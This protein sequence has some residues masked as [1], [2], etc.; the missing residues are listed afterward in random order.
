MNSYEPASRSISNSLRDHVEASQYELALIWGIQWTSGD[1]TFTIRL[2]TLSSVNRSILSDD[3]CHRKSFVLLLTTDMPY[4]IPCERNRRQ[5]VVT[6]LSC[7]DSSSDASTNFATLLAIHV[8]DAEI[9]RLKLAMMLRLM[10]LLDAKDVVV[11]NLLSLKPRKFLSG[12]T[13]IDDTSAVNV[14]FRRIKFIFRFFSCQFMNYY[15]FCGRTDMKYCR[16]MEPMM[17]CVYW[18]HR[19]AENDLKYSDQTN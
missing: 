9:L 16:I 2:L 13:D 1:I 4:W 19:C 8:S 17:S 12:W 7:L 10:A 15:C 5:M 14:R 3:A 11:S 18:R 6:R